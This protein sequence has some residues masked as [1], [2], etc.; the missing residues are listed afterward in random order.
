MVGL[1]TRYGVIAFQILNFGCQ[2]AVTVLF[3]V[4]DYD[5]AII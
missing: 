3:R 2:V 4:L 5:T 1:G